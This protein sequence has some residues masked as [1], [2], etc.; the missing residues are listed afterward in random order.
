MKIFLT[1][2]SGFLGKNFINSLIFKNYRVFA[3]S[4]KK[5]KSRKINWLYGDFDKN[6]DNQLKKSDVL[7]HFASTGINEKNAKNI[8]EINYFKSLN[9]L[10]NAIKNKC[11]KWLIISTSSEY[12]FN[13]K[14]MI[15]ISTKSNRIPKTDYGMSKALFTDASLR[16]AKKNNC[17]CRIMR[18]FPFH[19]KNENKNRLY[20]SINES[21]LKGKN[22]K[23]NNPNEIRSFSNVEKIVEILID[24]LNFEKR[25]FNNN[26]VWH[27]SENKIQSVKEFTKKIWKEKNANGKL[28]M[29]KKK[30]FFTHISDKK[31]LWQTN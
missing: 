7:V 24:A 25:K 14:K 28:I 31:S 12:G 22:F 10:H 5:R 15:K 30:K 17:K 26:Q 8:Y 21:I 11:K 1:G 6:W 9:L 3:P 16:L 29:N 2:A 23:I 13:S 4:R 20:P 18:I 27:V 19:G